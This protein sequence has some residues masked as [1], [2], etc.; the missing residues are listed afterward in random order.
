MKL[1]ECPWWPRKWTTKNDQ[2]ISS[3]QVAHDGTFETCELL[4]GDLMLEVDYNGR[5]V[6]G[7]HRL[8]GQRTELGE[9]EGLPSGL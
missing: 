6:V 3:A 1:R 9:G 5:T 4:A 8:F 2:D 7:R